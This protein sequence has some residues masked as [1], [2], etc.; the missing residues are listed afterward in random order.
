[1]TPF[2][3]E[4]T[5]DKLEK[6]EHLAFCQ[7]YAKEF[8]PKKSKGLQ[9]IGNIGTG[10]TTLLAAICNELMQKQYTCLFITMSSLL[11]KFAKHSFDNAGDITMLLKWLTM[12]DFVVIDDFGR[13]T[14]TD[15]RVE[16][17]FRV[18]DTLINEKVTVSSI[19]NR[20]Y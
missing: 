9:F 3:K 12:Y 10:K 18:V 15:K 2:F 17:A 7:E 14:Y 11:D 19:N 8:E 13:E 1:M 16:L 4:K 20:D 6:N 5:F